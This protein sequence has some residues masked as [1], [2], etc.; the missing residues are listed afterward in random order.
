MQTV[1]QSSILKM[2]FSNT[3]LL[4]IALI[5]SL[6]IANS[7]YNDA[8]ETF[9][10]TI[11]G[12]NIGNI[13]LKYN[14]ITWMNDGLMAI[15]FLMVGLE[16]KKELLEGQLSSVKKA[17][18]PI[19][20]AIGGAVLP[21]LIYYFINKGTPTQNGWGIPMATDIAF[22]L[23]VITALKDKVPSS[24]K[25]FL[26]AL[27][28]VDD[29]LAIIVIALFYSTGLHFDY[30]M[31]G[32]GVFIIQLI[33][34]RL[35]IKNLL[36]Y[37]VL[38]S[39]MWYCIHHSGIHAT[40]AGVLTAMAIPL[41]VASSSISPLEKLE[42]TLNIPVNYIIIPLF[43]LFN[44]NIKFE[45]EMLD[46]L[47]Q[48]LGLGIIL[49]LL[50]GKSVGIFSTCFI[51]TRLKI[52]TMPEGANWKQIFGVGI[53]GGIGFTMSI[54]VALLSFN[55]PH[56]IAAA[57]FCILIGSVMAAIIGYILLTLFRQKTLHKK[58]G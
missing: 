34:N 51:A 46:G 15:F 45:S 16:I 37:L 36:V 17:S 20:A 9:L 49:G 28:I 7:N 19:L 54:F 3:G 8:F 22:A 26:A 43:A 18:L 39:I 2:I 14:V 55:E 21:A 42:H 44:T 32:L 11:I 35:G 12:F 52:A 53:L 1:Q 47:Q 6:L 38:G 30:L 13:H 29:L 33:C 10:Q 56:H 50:I 48:P 57:K 40:I 5:T 27:A 58:I 4:V 41:R 24:L 25:V 23:A 31:M